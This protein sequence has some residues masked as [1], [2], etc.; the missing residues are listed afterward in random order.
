L[1]VVPVLVLVTQ[2]PLR[3]QTHNRIGEDLSAAIFAALPR[4]AVLLT[5]WDTL[6]MRSYKHCMEGVRPDVS[7]RAYDVRARATCDGLPGPLEDEVRAGR[8]AF[9]LFAFESSL[10]PLR[11]SFRLIPGPRFDLPYGQRYLDHAGTLYALELRE[12]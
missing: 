8:P 6:T 5:Y 11:G 1:L 10:E 4:D 12:P 2:L 3:D 7:L 9:A